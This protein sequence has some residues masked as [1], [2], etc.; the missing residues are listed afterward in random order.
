MFVCSMLPS[1]CSI[2]HYIVTLS[3][4]TCILLESFGQGYFCLHS[5]VL[6]CMLIVIPST[7]PLP[8]LPADNWTVNEIWW[9]DG[10]SPWGQQSASSLTQRGRV[11][12]WARHIASNIHLNSHFYQII[13][14]GDV[15]FNKTGHNLDAEFSKSA[16]IRSWDKIYGTHVY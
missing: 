5:V 4:V 15:W 14:D 16:I 10:P 8:W 12:R 13:T 6:L 2:C 7:E 11:W 1:V 9:T 3:A